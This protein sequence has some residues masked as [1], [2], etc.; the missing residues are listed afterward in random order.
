MPETNPSQVGDHLRGASHFSPSRLTCPAI[1]EGPYRRSLGPQVTRIVEMANDQEIIDHRLRV[2]AVPALGS[3]DRASEPGRI[4]AVSKAMR[5]I[6]EVVRRSAPTDIPVLIHGEPDTGKKLIACEVHRQ[7]GRA[8]GPFVHVVCGALRESDLAENL[9]GRGEYGTERDDH[10][11]LPLLMEACGGTL[12]LEE[13]S[14]LP[15]W[16]QVRLL[17]FLQEAQRFG[18][19]RHAGAGVDVRVIASSTVDPSA[20]MARRV[21]LSSLYYYLK[22]VDIHVPPLR[23]RSQD[24]CPLVGK[25][26]AIA[27]AARVSQGGKAPCHFAKEALRCLVEYDWP[28]NMLQL[29]S[30]VAHVVM[31]TD[32]DEIVPMQ[33]RELLSETAPG[34]NSETISVPLLGGLKDIERAVV[35]TVIERCRGNKAEAARVLGLH[36]R[37]LYRIL[38]RKAPVTDDATPLPLALGPNVGDCA[39]STVVGAWP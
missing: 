16:G 34:D 27:N 18:G 24:I 7:S 17:E 20:A 21:L 5:K 22:V 8:A 12:F 9:F 23:H 4:I 28:G 19:A 6:L 36:R 15:L 11:P 10:T 39:A 1:G 32:G 3:G 26:L 29:A 31:L 13:V 37:E 2:D 25:Y 30:I 38:Q 14:Q 35:T 33:V